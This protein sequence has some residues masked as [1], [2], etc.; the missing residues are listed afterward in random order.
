MTKGWDGMEGL[1]ESMM[2]NCSSCGEEVSGKVIR[3]IGGFPV[4][5]ECKKEGDSSAL[6]SSSP[7]RLPRD[8]GW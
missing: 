1:T 8:G 5:H 6:R 7:R 3:Y 2:F 4:I